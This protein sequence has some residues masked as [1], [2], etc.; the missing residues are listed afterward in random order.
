MADS[1]EVEDGPGEDNDEELRP[2]RPDEPPGEPQV[3]SRDCAVAQVEPDG[4]TVA[5]RNGSATHEAAD[6]ADD[7]RAEEALREAQVDRE[8]VETCQAVSIEV[9]SMETRRDVSIAG[10]RDSASMDVRSTTAV[11]ETDQRTSTNAEDV[12]EPPQH[13]PQPQPLPIPP[14]E[15]AER[16]NEPPSCDHAPTEDEADAAGVSE[17]VEDHE[18]RPKNLE[19]VSEP[20]RERSKRRCRGYSPRRA[21]G[22]PDDPGGETAAPGGPRT[23]QEGPI[24]GSSEGGG[25]MSA[26]DRDTRPGGCRGE[27]VESRGFK[28]VRDHRKGV[29]GA[30]LDGIRPGSKRNERV[31]DTNPPCRDRWP[32]GRLGERDGLGDVEDDL[33]RRSDG[34][35]DETDGMRG[36]KHGATSGA[37]RD[38][39]RVETTPLAEG[40]T[41][42]YRRR[43]RTTTDA[44]EP[45]QPPNN[46]HRLPTNHANPPRRRG[47]LKRRSTRVSNPGRPTRSHGRVKAGSGGSDASYMLYMDRR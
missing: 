23:Y 19:N 16:R 46:D 12:P 41:S 20:E 3:E 18:K 30:E 25:E 32:G 33:E 5:E 47:R 31:G 21:R 2:Q 14:D 26:S 9:E 8:S 42:Q 13:S 10:E 27:Q 39:K 35:G 7:G 4:K 15:L 43:T 22:D 6:A 45:S 1:R 40:E 24:V 38:S 28:G 11:D 17:C 37:R 36:W 29:D 34:E 44:P